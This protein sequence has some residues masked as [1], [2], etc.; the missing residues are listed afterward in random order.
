MIKKTVCLNMIVK[1]ESHIIEETLLKLTKKIKFDYWVISDTGSTD[2]TKEIIVNFFKNVDIPG[3]IYD[4]EWVNFA[5]NRSKALEYAYNK[6]D[7]IL[8]FDADDEICGDFKLP[9]NF[10]HDGY[11][12]KF[13]DENGCHYKRMLLVNNRKKWIYKSVIHEYICNCEPIGDTP[14]I[15][16]NYYV[17]SGRLGYRNQ[18]P[19]KY[20]N[21]AI[22]LEKAH[23]IALKE[24]DDLYLRY[25]FYCANSYKDAGKNVEAIK[26]Y[27][28]TLGQNNWPQEKYMS[29][30]NLFECYS[31][32]NSM[33]TGFFYLI[34]SIKYDNQRAEC[35][36]PLISHYCAKEM[37]TVSYNFYLNI[38][39]F[40][41]N[42]Y[43]YSSS[44][45]NDKLF[46]RNM[47]YDLL[48]PYYM[49]I[50]ADKVKERTTGIKMYE[51][52]FTKKFKT[53]DE[54]FIGN[55]LFNLQFFIEDAINNNNN[56]NFIKLFQEYIDFLLQINYP[57]FKHDFLQK[58][59]KYGLNTRNIFKLL[60]SKFTENECKNSKKILFF[61]GYAPY[62][63]ND[64]YSLTNAIGGSEKAV[65]YLSKQFP[66][67]YEIYVAGSVQEETINNITYVNLENLPKLIET[68][69]FHTIIVSR[70]ISFFE[71]YP[72]FSAYQTYIWGHDTILHN[73]GCNTSQNDILQKWSNKITGCICQTEWHMDLFTKI[74]PLLKD[75][76]HIINNGIPLDNFKYKL[77]KIQNRFIYSSC[78]ERGL[79]RLLELWPSI[80]ENIP[81]AELF[82]ASYNSFP[83]NDYENKLYEIIKKYNSI[84]HVGKLNSD[85][86]YELM[87]TAEYWLYPTSWPETSCITAMEMLYSEVICVYYSLAGLVNTLGDY[88]IPVEKGNEVET[89]I[90]LTNKRKNEIITRG[91][92]YALSCSWENRYNEWSKLLFKN[93][94]NNKKNNDGKKCKN[95]I[96]EINEKCNEKNNKFIKVI[97]LKRRPDRKNNMIQKLQNVSIN[98]NEYEIIEAVDG[99]E[100]ESTL[101]I[102]NLFEGNDFNY[103]KG[104]I[105]C[106]L[107]HIHLWEK[108]VDDKKNDYYVI[109]EDDV[110]FVDNFKEKLEKSIE[111]FLQSKIEYA[112]IG[113]YQLKKENTNKND[114][115]FINY[116]YYDW[117][118]QYSYIISK[119]G[120][121][122]LL[123]SIKNNGVKYAIDYHGIYTRC[124]DVYFLNE[125]IVYAEALQIHNN[126]DT[127][128]QN[129]YDYLDFSNIDEE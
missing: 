72:N 110:T 33:E 114:I 27:R 123:E 23:E 45:I 76:I 108:L 22:V 42:E 30:L 17:V 127:D 122:K 34:E 92:E 95:E 8:I 100:L 68:N 116:N 1:N 44:V 82:I 26:W 16:E 57:L 125:Y 12:L 117:S 59:E 29:C 104:V 89:I 69:A 119:S 93:E 15:D 102:K 9:I 62:L 99:K 48:L 79:D 126:Q 56:N 85:K 18:Q 3:E 98:E 112:L 96:I 83:S 71:N 19:D 87:S 43:F 46:I 120:S 64:T 107:S 20:L 66:E 24:N 86:L 65:L 60:E 106:A 58:Y 105:G 14:L 39:P 118:G 103:R 128:I 78:S 54:H 52:I 38:K 6:S 115:Q 49:I 70:Y 4:D 61:V 121:K 37:S 91:K 97:N 111:L 90:N 13:G 50:V 75:K 51:I 129:E 5:Y 94:E 25:A 2:K 32:I 67:N 81:N 21:D 11:H 73:Y 63:W 53:N 113:A 47:D 84:F 7:Y 74:H 109:L 31:K 35:L 80:I 40:F 55:M 36:I 28:I 88:G 101:Y 77:K 41:E 10:I 124:F